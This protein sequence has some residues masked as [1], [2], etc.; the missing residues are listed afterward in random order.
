MHRSALAYA[1]L[2]SVS[3]VQ[4]PVGVDV[5][6]RVHPF[7]IADLGRKAQARVPVRHTENR[8]G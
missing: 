4:T 3:V 6:A 8:S 1:T 5:P 2:R 7:D